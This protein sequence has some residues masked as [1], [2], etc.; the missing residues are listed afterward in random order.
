MD[1]HRDMTNAQH[2]AITKQL[3]ASADE[4]AYNHDGVGEHGQAAI[5][6][7]RARELRIHALGAKYEEHLPADGLDWDHDDITATLVSVRM[8]RGTACV[9]DHGGFR[10]YWYRGTEIRQND[11]PAEYDGDRMVRQSNEMW[12]TNTGTTT[13]TFAGMLQTLKNS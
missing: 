13:H 3:A 2:I 7:Q 4:A 9:T 6:R 1:Y 12:E 8:Y 5:M 10:T 11:T